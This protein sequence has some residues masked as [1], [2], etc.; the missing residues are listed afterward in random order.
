M[1]KLSKIHL[2]KAPK[3]FV[4][5]T[6]YL[7]YCKLEEKVSRGIRSIQIRGKDSL[8]F[9]Y[10]LYEDINFFNSLKIQALLLM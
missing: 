6:I 5:L 2:Y 9:C 7:N 1:K 4:P 3:V 10:L 8:Y